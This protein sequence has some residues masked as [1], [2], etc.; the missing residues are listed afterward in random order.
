M[1]HQWL[2]TREARWCDETATPD[3]CAQTKSSRVQVSTRA[4]VQQRQLPTTV[5]ICRVDP[6]SRR[7]MSRDEFVHPVGAG[8]RQHRDQRRAMGLLMLAGFGLLV[9]GR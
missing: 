7:T 5:K 2:K 9:A 8:H 6:T 3:S 4:V 1:V